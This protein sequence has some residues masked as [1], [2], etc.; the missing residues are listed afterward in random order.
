MPSVLVKFISEF[1]GYQLTPQ[2]CKIKL[3]LKN[4]DDK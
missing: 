2:G 4:C 3:A 1:T